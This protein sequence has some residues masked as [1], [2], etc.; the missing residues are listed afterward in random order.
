[1]LNSKKDFTECF[2][3]IISPTLKYFTESNAGFECGKTGV[4]YGE[5]IAKLESFMRLLRGLAPFFSGGGQHKEFEEKFSTVLL[6]EP[7]LN[8]LNIGAKYKTAT[9]G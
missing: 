9:K 4:S 8:I 5:Q 2:L 7:I 3:K 6:T 1:M